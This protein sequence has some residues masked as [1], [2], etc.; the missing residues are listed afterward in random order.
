MGCMAE[1]SLL[2]WAITAGAP[3]N[4][5]GCDQAGFESELRVPVELRARSALRN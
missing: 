4:R 3:S 5:R 1:L 2:A